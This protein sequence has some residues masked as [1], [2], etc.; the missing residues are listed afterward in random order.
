MYTKL[1]GTLES[2]M[3]TCS[4]AT[5]IQLRASVRGAVKVLI[6]LVMET[7]WVGVRMGA[8]HEDRQITRN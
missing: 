1:A 5:R 7:P 4:G 8:M 2:P 3:A 6:P